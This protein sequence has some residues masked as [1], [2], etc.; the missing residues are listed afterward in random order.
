M[1]R[2]AIGPLKKSVLRVL[3]GVM[4]VL[5]ALGIAGTRDHKP[6]TNEVTLSV[7]PH[8]SFRALLAWQES[9]AYP[10]QHMARTGLVEASERLA[11]RRKSK[12][13]KLNG[14]WIA[15]G[16][17]EGS[18]TL[19]IAVDPQDSNRVFAGS[20]SG[21]IWFSDGESKANWRRLT[22]GYPVTGVASIA[23]DPNDSN[24]LLIGTGE[25]YGYESAVGG[26]GARVSRGSYGIGIL[27]SEDGG[28]SWT[29]S[30]DWRL[31]QTTGVQ[32]LEFDPNDSQTIW[33]ATTEGVYV[34]RD[35]GFTW[36][37][38]L[39]VVMATSVSVHPQ[40]P[41]SVAV[42]CGGL[43]SDKRGIYNT[44]DGGL[45]W[46]KAGSPVPTDFMGKIILDRAPSQ[47]DRLYASIGDDGFLHPENPRRSWLVRSDDNGQSWIVV[48][49]QNFAEFQGWYSHY[50]AVDP[51][52][53]DH[54]YVGGVYFYSSQNAGQTLDFYTRTLA[55]VYPGVD[56]HALT[57]APSNPQVY[58]VA[59]DF[60]VTRSTDG[61]QSYQGWNDGFQLLQFYNG[62]A[63]TK[64]ASFY[65]SAQ[66]IGAR[67]MNA[68]GMWSMVNGSEAG[69]FFI[70]AN[71]STKIYTNGPHH[72]SFHRSGE[73]TKPVPF[74]PNGN[75]TIVDTQDST[76]FVAPFVMSTVDTNRI[77]AGRDYVYRSDTG[78]DNWVLMNGGQVLD[79]NPI[80]YLVAS[81]QDVDTAYA[82][83]TPKSTRMHAFRTSDGGESWQDITQNL[84][85]LMPSDL[86]IDEADD[87]HLLLLFSGF[88]DQHLLETRDAGETW[89]DLARGELPKLPCNAVAMDPVDAD[90]L[91]L[92]NDLTAYASQDAGYTWFAIPDGLPEALQVSDFALNAE[93]DQV[94]LASH[95]NG[96]FSMERLSS[97]PEP[98]I[99]DSAYVYSLSDIQVRGTDQSQI[100]LVNSSSL[101][102]AEVTMLAMTAG[103]K[104]AGTSDITIGP[105]QRHSIAASDLLSNPEALR[106][107]QIRSNQPLNVWVDVLRSEHRY[108]YSAQAATTI[109][110]VP[111]VAKDTN[112]FLTE[113]GLA[114]PGGVIDRLELLADNRQTDLGRTKR[115]FFQERADIR[116]WLGNDLQDIDWATISAS[117]PFSAIE[118]FSRLTGKNEVAGL[119]LSG[120]SA[121]ELAFLHIAKDTSLFWTGMVYINI[122]PEPISAQE[123]F[124]SDQGELLLS[125]SATLQKNEKRILLVDAQTQ[126]SSDPLVPVGSDWCLIQTSSPIIGYELFGSP[127]ESPHSVFAGLQGS[128]Q[129][130]DKLQ[131]G[132][133]VHSADDWV[134]L[135]VVNLSSAASDL[136]FV[137]YADNGTRIAEQSANLAAKAK[138]SLLMRDLF[139]NSYAQGGWVEVLADNHAIN[140]FQLYGNNGSPRTHLGGI[141]ALSAN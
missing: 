102:N 17:N 31:Q 79:G 48:S 89:Q 119:A 91:Y 127:I 114:N 18:R 110:Y 54:L 10:A 22:T 107:V 28:S 97:L 94:I 100:I 92:G 19:A 57:F 58:Y 137:H 130:H 87:R 86:F 83:T 138:R 69:L 88:Q 74:C 67:T 50:P 72:W 64:E 21:G 16:P 41:Q 140:G 135:V 96:A 125:R 116:L 45:T 139:P 14:A 111:H 124:Y 104:Q 43:G 78:G 35:R 141:N 70:D 131:F 33:S 108:G 38:K 113:L 34:S 103:G 27:K 134:G 4:V 29:M 123:L 11:K 133:S 25:V 26:T 106:W 51:V 93:V 7:G 59:S 56:N 77:F 63:L 85:D 105:K 126:T 62:T 32:D 117:Q 47:P 99:A 8:K 71:D 82:V 75:C 52:N 2:S 13:K 55:D 46:Q 80:G 5:I 3:A 122:N 37:R 68:F 136:M 39:D 15:L 6:P 81:S 66:D 73:N 109:A 20:A 30:L 9:R 98:T 121:T 115:S 129:T 95:G 36:S 1:D 90:I 12:N 84:P 24:F 128:L 53:S 132:M 76:N 61:G 49:R 42:A 118:T 65:A 101:T 120:E 40:N 23:I 60:G 44:S 112:Q